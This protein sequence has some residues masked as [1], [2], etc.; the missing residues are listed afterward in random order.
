M[1]G[2]RLIATSTDFFI[3]C[4][5]RLEKKEKQGFIGWENI[6]NELYFK[7]QIRERAGKVLASQKHLIDIANFC[8]FLW[9]MIEDR[10]EEKKC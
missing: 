4:V 10:K 3:A 9:Q 5:K 2:V 7:T 8:S 1:E 6:M